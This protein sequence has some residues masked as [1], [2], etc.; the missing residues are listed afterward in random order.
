MEPDR[1]FIEFYLFIYHYINII[2]KYN[3][4]NFIA[5]C[6]TENQIL[7]INFQS[8]NILRYVASLV[9]INWL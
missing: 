3:Y 8:K 4:S 2:M 5:K 9:P 6:F 1:F 7:V